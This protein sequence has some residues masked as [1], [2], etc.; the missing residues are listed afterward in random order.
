MTDMPSLAVGWL[1]N[2][3]LPLNSFSCLLKCCCCTVH[4]PFL[5]AHTQ[6]TK[7]PL[8]SPS[9]CPCVCLPACPPLACALFGPS[10]S[11]LVVFSD[12]AAL[13]SLSAMAAQENHGE[14]SHCGSK[15]PVSC[16]TNKTL[17]PPQLSIH[18]NRCAVMQRSRV[19]ASA[20]CMPGV[21]SLQHGAMCLVRRLH[22]AKCTGHSAQC[23]LGTILCVV[24]RLQCPLQA[25]QCNAMTMQG[26]HGTMCRVHAKLSAW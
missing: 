22:G 17:L 10:F 16:P 1:A 14:M 21:F 9:A 3:G 13:H 15:I 18:L 7:H 20:T 26:A 25:R 5:N 8:T 4:P 11:R 6:F 2:G 12:A 19:S 23:A 24:Q